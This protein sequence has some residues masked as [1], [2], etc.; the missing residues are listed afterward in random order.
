MV[1]VAFGQSNSANLAS[2]RSESQRA[3]YNFHSG[4]LYRAKDPMIG[5]DGMGGSV[6]PKVGDG[7]Q[8]AGIYDAVIFA[9]IGVNATSV[10]EW[11]PGTKLHKKLLNVLSQLD[12][13][14]LPVTHLLWHQ[15][16]Q[17]AR[18]GTSPAEYFEAFLVIVESL[19]A[20]GIAAPIYVSQ[21]TRCYETAKNPPLRAAQRKLAESLDGV[22]AG[23]DTDLLGPEY[24]YDGCHFAENGVSAASQL[25]V[26]A[27][28]REGAM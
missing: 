21:A 17:D 8:T 13:S 16:E 26:D 18:A 23:P 19:R 22:F 14:R 6:W 5:A 1:A 11:L 4:K 27:L 2:T 20:N 24:R 3:T 25:W 9:S 10:L 7:L 28:T 12:R 15:G